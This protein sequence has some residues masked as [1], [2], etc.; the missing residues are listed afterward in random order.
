MIIEIGGDMECEYCGH[1]EDS[2]ISG[3]GKCGVA[4]CDCEQ[5]EVPGDDDGDDD[6]DISDDD[7]DEDPDPDTDI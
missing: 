2:H 5:F 7:D 1:D 4:R 6:N 3:T